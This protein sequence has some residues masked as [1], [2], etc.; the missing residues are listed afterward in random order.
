MSPGSARAAEAARHERLAAR[1][2]R[3]ANRGS[4]VRLGRAEA[5]RGVVMFLSTH[6]LTHQERD[7][8]FA[9]VP[10]MEALRFNRN[11]AVNLVDGWHLET[12]DGLVGGFAR[13]A[14]AAFLDGTH[15]LLRAAGQLTDSKAAELYCKREH[16]A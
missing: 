13:E 10:E 3:R 14:F 11:V 16:P 6:A 1:G 5:A 4:E 12:I 9:S 7:A 8:A 2:A 15:L